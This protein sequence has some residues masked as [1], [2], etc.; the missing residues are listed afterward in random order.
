MKDAMLGPVEA[1]KTGPGAVVASS[2]QQLGQAVQ[3]E[4]NSIIVL[5]PWQ[6]RLPMPSTAPLPGPHR[7]QSSC[8]L[9]YLPYIFLSAS[10]GLSSSQGP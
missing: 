4:A 1:P 8:A 6:V 3:T 2:N 7:L 5:R 9:K 10:P